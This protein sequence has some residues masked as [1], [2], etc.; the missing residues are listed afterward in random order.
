[1]ASRMNPAVAS[2]FLPMDVLDAI[3][4]LMPFSNLLA[5]NILECDTSR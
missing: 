2:T 5:K 4:T 1:M 3:D